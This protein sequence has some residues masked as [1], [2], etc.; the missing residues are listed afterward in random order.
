M[1]TRVTVTF[2]VTD[3]QLNMYNQDMNNFLDALSDTGIE[4]VNVKEDKD[5]TG[6]R[7]NLV[8]MAEIDS[9][10]FFDN[11]S[12]DTKS[13]NYDYYDLKNNEEVF[14]YIKEYYPQELKAL[15]NG[16]I[17]YLEVYSDSF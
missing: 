10:L 3:E 13:W 11:I 15:K 17:D 7:A 8:A 9:E 4:K 6:V 16:E 14:E 5:F 12:M 2:E 1:T